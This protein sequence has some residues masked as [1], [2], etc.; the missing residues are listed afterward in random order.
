MKPSEPPPESPAS[1][2]EGAPL[3]RFESLTKRLLAVSRADLGREERD[4]PRAGE[5]DGGRSTS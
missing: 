4:A 1:D 5:P 3:R 2:A